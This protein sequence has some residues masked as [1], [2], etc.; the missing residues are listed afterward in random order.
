MGKEV[1]PLQEYLKTV[2]RR[3]DVEEAVSGVEVVTAYKE[4]VGE[5]ISKLSQQMQYK[6]GCL[7]VTIAS[8]ALRQELSYKRQ[9]LT[10]KI[11]QKIGKDILKDVIFR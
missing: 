7:Y 3:L 6:Q 4:I 9:S 1:Q 2:Y 8:A 10:E 11:N 5:L